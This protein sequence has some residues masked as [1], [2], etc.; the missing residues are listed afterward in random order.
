MLRVNEKRLIVKLGLDGSLNKAWSRD[1]Y[2][3]LYGLVSDQ[4]C[5]QCTCLFALIVEMHLITEPTSC[6]KYAHKIV[7][8]LQV[9]I[10]LFGD[11]GRSP[12]STFM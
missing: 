9:K 8:G 5:I 2:H 7:V 11:P 1:W 10:D 12:I 6:R 4:E 3:W